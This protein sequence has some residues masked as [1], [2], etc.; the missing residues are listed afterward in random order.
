MCDSIKLNRQCYYSFNMSNS[1]IFAE[2]SIVLWGQ[3]HLW[4]YRSND[5]S[6]IVHVA[7]QPLNGFFYPKNSSWLTL[8]I[9]LV[10]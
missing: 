1:S 2:D 7:L 3:M 4:A 8:L 9:S 5:L 10:Y 6:Q